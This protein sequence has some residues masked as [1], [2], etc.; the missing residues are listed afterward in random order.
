MQDRNPL[1]PIAELRSSLDPD[2]L[3]RVAFTLESAGVLTDSRRIVIDEL[4]IAGVAIDS[5]TRAVA[6]DVLVGR[7][8]D[9][10]A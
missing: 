4:R 6:P 5:T 8:V 7:L 2:R 10:V 9:L 1:A 3:Q